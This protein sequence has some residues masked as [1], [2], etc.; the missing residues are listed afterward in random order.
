VSAVDDPRKR[1]D[2]MTG[3]VASRSLG[4]VRVL[5]VDL[6]FVGTLPAGTPMTGPPGRTGVV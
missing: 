3:I 5:G 6:P 2:P 4:F 1:G